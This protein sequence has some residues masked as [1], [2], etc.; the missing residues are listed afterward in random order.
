MHTSWCHLVSESWSSSR[1]STRPGD[2]AAWA[3]RCLRRTTLPRYSR[4]SLFA[5]VAPFQEHMCQLRADR[6]KVSADLIFIVSMGITMVKLSKRKRQT[7]CTRYFQQIYPAADSRLG[8]TT[9]CL[10]MQILRHRDT[11]CHCM[12]ASSQSLT[13]TSLSPSSSSY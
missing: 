1:S 3:H 4:T 5:S 13:S 8:V 6:S 9:D 11:D 12:F 2:G 10:L 7:N